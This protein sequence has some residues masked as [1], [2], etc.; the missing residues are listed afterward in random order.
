MRE[1]YMIEVIVKFVIWKKFI[2]EMW[3]VMI[4]W[5]LNLNFMNERDV[6]YVFIR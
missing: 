2:N 5:N 6:I 1:K 4:R 3:D